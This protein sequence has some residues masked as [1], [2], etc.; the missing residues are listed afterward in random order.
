[1]R[2]RASSSTNTSSTNGNSDPGQPMRILMIASEVTPFIKTGGLADAVASLSASFKRMGHDVRV[3]IPR[4]ADL[5]MGDQSVEACLDSMGV[6]MGNALEWCSVR[7]VSGL[8]KVPVYLIEF[9]RYFN[10]PCLYH[11]PNM[12]D[13]QDNAARFGFFVRAALQM[14]IDTGFSPDIVHVHDWQTAAAPAYLKTWFWDN[15][16]LGRAASV[17]TIH[18]IAHQGAYDGG[19]YPYLGLGG[20]S[21]TADKF[22]DHGRVNLLKGGIH[23]ADMVNT[24]SPT[25]AREVTTPFGGFGLAPRL[26][27]RG[28]DFVGILNGADYTQWSPEKDP[29]IPARYSVED[30]YGKTVCKRELQEE[31]HLA[32]DD[33]IAVVGAVGRFVEQKG[34]HL[35]AQAID[36]IV[37]DMHVQFV[38]LG[39]GQGYLEQFFGT[40]PGRYPGR[41]GSYIGFS[42]RLAHLIEAGCDFFVMP[43]LY[44]PCGLNQMYSLR[45]GTLPI[46]RATGGLDDTVDNYNEAAGTGTGFKFWEPAAR[47]LYYTVGW[48]ISTYYDRPHHIRSMIRAAMDKRFSWGDS[49]RNYLA[50]YRKA[51]ENKRRYDTR[52]SGR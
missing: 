27:D 48:A 7:Q 21:F 19:V 41:A 34:F 46:V 8:G 31:F 45:Y 4:Y 50:V 42:N 5:Q 39:S 52:C 38:I 15:P 44:E 6:W 10:R 9:D 1:M 13:Y 24:V 51:R 43:S 17:L 3:V 35:L 47:G 29:L 49:A 25:H 30:L 40:L 11:A 20:D 36:G 22:E 26:A 16:I 33:H 32:V 23:F 28:D 37:Q 14:C 18:N 12:E 2:P